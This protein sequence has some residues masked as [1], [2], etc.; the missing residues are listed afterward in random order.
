MDLTKYDPTAHTAIEFLAEEMF[1]DY[2]DR[3]DVYSTV[4]PLV[5]DAV[6]GMQPAFYVQS[7]DHPNS[8]ALVLDLRL[9]K[10][11]IEGVFSAWSLGPEGQQWYAAR[12]QR[13]EVTTRTGKRPT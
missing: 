3:G 4:V 7:N 10:A 2:V 8:N 6:R 9:L 13:R 1:L 11:F 5:R 12:R